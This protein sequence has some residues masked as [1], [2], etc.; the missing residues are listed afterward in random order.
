MGVVAIQQL[1]VAN[2]QLLV[3]LPHG[4]AV[5]L[6]LPLVPVLAEESHD[7]AIEQ[8]QRSGCEIAVTVEGGGRKGG[9]SKTPNNLTKKRVRRIYARAEI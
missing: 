9:E 6:L 5:F 3:R 2:L 1:D 8:E 4:L 7:F